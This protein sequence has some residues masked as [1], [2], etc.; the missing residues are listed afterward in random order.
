MAQLKST[1]ITGNLS[2]TGEIVEQGEKIKDKYT[3]KTYVD[4][5]TGE[6][7]YTDSNETSTIKA[8][9][10]SLGSSITKKLDSTT[11]ASTYETK[12]NAIT[13]L[14]V[15]GKTITYTKGN[16]TT[17]TITT[18]DTNTT[19]NQATSS[20]LGLVKIGYTESGKNY[21]VELNSSGQMYV[22]VPWTSGSGVSQSA[23]EQY[24]DNA[25]SNYNADVALATYYM[26][27]IALFSTSS[28]TYRLYITLYNKSGTKLTYSTLVT[29]LKSKGCTSKDQMYSCTGM[30]GS[31]GN[32][33]MGV[34]VNSNN[35]ILNY[36]SSSGVSQYTMSQPYSF[37]DNVYAV[38]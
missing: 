3:L 34:H 36:N 21:P 12:A 2:V 26:H 9:L 23:M 38:S 35:I 25:I 32:F 29:W 16:G 10:D 4:S 13:G 11:A 7:I 20:S 17:G 27:R 15:S 14:R 22:N 31:S 28:P 33:V 24:V 18:Q 30:A 1:N 19:Y 8:A 37:T 5:L 6:D